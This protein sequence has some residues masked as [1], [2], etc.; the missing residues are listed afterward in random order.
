MNLNLEK[1]FIKFSSNF[2]FKGI[3]KPT[4]TSRL[5]I[6][7][8]IEFTKKS[9]K[10]LDLG[11]GGGIISACLYLINKKANF[12]LSDLSKKAV[13]KAKKN[14]KIFKGNFSY[15]SGDCFNPWKGEVFDLIINDVSGVSSKIAKIS[16]WFKNVPIDKSAEGI[17]LLK[18]VIKNSKKFM[19]KNSVIILPIISLSNVKKGK[20]IVRE[21]LKI[22]KQY[23][24]DW[25]LPKAMIKHEKLL[26]NLK[27]KN[28]VHFKK[29]YGIIICSTIIIVAKKC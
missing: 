2:D 28:L 4:H 29:K 16:P 22:I 9:K 27:K 25:P 23:E 14:L 15:K 1:E 10:I 13:R 20:K 17:S 5:L 11:C 8:S 21:S 24:F 6:N 7:S 26:N 18:K 19:H 12:F 3:F